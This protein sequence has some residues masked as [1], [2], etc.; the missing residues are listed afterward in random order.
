MQDSAEMRVHLQVAHMSTG[1]HRTKEL[2]VRGMACDVPG[3]PGPCRFSTR[4]F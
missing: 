4:W 2:P 1:C 3:D